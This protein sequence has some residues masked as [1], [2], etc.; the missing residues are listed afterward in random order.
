[1]PPQPNPQPST[2]SSPEPSESSQTTENELKE[3][4]EP[5]PVTQALQEQVLTFKVKI[6]RLNHEL[7]QLR[8][9]VQTLVSG[10][11]I[12]VLFAIGISTWS[13]LRFIALEQINRIE[14]EKA[15][16]SRL[17]LSE[18]I[19][20]LEE[21]FQQLNQQLSA[22]SENVS[23][24][25]AADDQQLQRLRDRLTILE[26]QNQLRDSSE[27]EPRT[28]QKPDPTSSDRSLENEP[29]DQDLENEPTPSP[30]LS[31]AAEAGS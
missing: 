28:D 2:R 23:E 10:M 16:T 13:F 27:S 26:L 19:A 11:V 1:M 4:W 22:Q 8:G 30:T 25:L 5:D 20:Q 31:P 3:S 12:A 29:T 21:N 15:S 17:E 24:Q 14:A 18:D 9:W 7:S 6:D